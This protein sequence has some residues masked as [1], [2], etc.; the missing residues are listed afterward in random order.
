MGR[1]LEGVF[2]EA[3]AVNSTAFED[4]DP[5]TGLRAFVGSKTETALLAFAKEMGWE[6]YQRVRERQRSCR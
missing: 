3:I 2:N 6:E 5:D 1:A 4:V